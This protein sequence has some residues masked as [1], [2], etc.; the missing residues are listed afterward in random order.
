MS[1]TET[2]SKH[3]ILLLKHNIPTPIGEKSNAYACDVTE[4]IAS[5]NK[6]IY[7]FLRFDTYCK[8]YPDLAMEQKK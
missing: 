2:L 5:F 1:M 4:S 7:F 6:F 8:K 3:P